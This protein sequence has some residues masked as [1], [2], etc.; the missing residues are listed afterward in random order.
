MLLGT[1]GGGHVNCSFNQFSFAD[2]ASSITAFELRSRQAVAILQR[3][4]V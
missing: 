3:R 1:Y 4:Q 2:V